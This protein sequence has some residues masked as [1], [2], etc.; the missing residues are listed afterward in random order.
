MTYKI[1]ALF[2]QLRLH[3]HYL[4][5]VLHFILWHFQSPPRWET[6]SPINSR[7]SWSVWC[8]FTWWIWISRWLRRQ[9]FR[10]GD[11]QLL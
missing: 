7:F 1:F 2:L 6:V 9:S 11:K 8:L 3:L 4:F 5:C 10:T